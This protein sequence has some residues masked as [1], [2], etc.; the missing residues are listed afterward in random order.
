M[1]DEPAQDAGV[2]IDNEMRFVDELVSDDRVGVVHVMRGNLPEI[3][4]AGNCRRIGKAGKDERTG[5]DEG[6]G[7]GRDASERVGRLNVDRIRSR[8]GLRQTVPA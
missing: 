2:R 1:G 3:L 7:I 5:D 4:R 8:I 6:H